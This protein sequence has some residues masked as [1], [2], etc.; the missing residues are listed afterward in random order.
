MMP[1]FAFY[2][3]YHAICSYLL[4]YR[5]LCR[6]AFWEEDIAF[7]CGIYEHKVNHFHDER[8]M[9]MNK[10]WSFFCLS[11]LTVFMLSGCTAS[12]AVTATPKPTTAATTQPSLPPAAGSVPSFQIEGL[13]NGDVISQGDLSLQVI[14]SNFTLVDRNSAQASNPNE[15]HIHYWLDSN[16]TDPGAAVQIDKDP[17]HILLQGL[18]AG[19]HILTLKLVG[20]D[21]Q[22]ISETTTDIISFMVKRPSNNS[23][24]PTSSPT[25]KPEKASPAPTTKSTA[26]ANEADKESASFTVV[27]LKND[28]VITTEDLKFQIKIK[29]LEMVDFKDGIPAQAGQGHIHMWLDTTSTEA[30]AALKVYNDPKHIVIKNI[31]EGEHTIFIGLVSNDHQTIIGHRQAITFTVKRG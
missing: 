28:D 13:H 21:H 2:I 10:N 1:I 20:T 16:P 30:S 14:L 19:Q 23:S 12:Q 6:I 11:L 22:P 7:A 9:L 29:G 5:N 8:N 4:E 24:E 3:N 31:T 15:G 17:E 25:P 26:N 18:T 27:G